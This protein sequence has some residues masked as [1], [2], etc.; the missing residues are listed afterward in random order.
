MFFT[1]D[2]DYHRC[3]SV[4]VGDILSY[5]SVAIGFVDISHTINALGNNICIHKSITGFGGLCSFSNSKGSALK[6]FLVQ[7]ESWFLHWVSLDGIADIAN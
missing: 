3:I 7:L 6:P 4:F 2:I 1:K 5:C